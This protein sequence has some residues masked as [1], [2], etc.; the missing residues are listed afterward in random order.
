MEPQCAVL[1][2][3]D[4]VYAFSRF[5]GGV[6]HATFSST[7][8]NTRGKARAKY[9]E[10]GEGSE[11]EGRGV[12]EELNLRDEELTGLDEELR[13]A[14][15]LVEEHVLHAAQLVAV[16]VMEAL[17]AEAELRPPVEE[18]GAGARDVGDGAA[19]GW[20]T[21]CAVLKI[22]IVP[23]TFFHANQDKMG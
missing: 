8:T 2:N 12:D 17:G 16:V 15:G 14:G 7:Q 13:V 4:S 6:K 18:V 21:Q 11:F 23:C 5:A 9:C 20:I 10:N 1:K 22:R 19:A 3:A